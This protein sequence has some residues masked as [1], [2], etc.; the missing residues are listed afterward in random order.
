[1][2]NDRGLDALVPKYGD[3][4]LLSPADFA[5]WEVLYTDGSVL[6]ETE[7]RSY[8]DIDRSRLKSFR[9]IHGGEMLIEMFPPPGATGYN[10]VY[11]RRNQVGTDGRRVVI[12]IGW[13]PMGPIVVIDPAAGTYREEAGFDPTDPDFAPPQPMPGEPQDYLLTIP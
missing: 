12:M 2:T 3:R 5:Y 6:R 4:D 11:R 10:L 1:M 13:P 9:I 7:G 8:P